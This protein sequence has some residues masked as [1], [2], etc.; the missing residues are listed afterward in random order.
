[1]ATTITSFL[2]IADAQRTTYNSAKPMLLKNALHKNTGHG[3]IA[4]FQGSI[5][6][7]WTALLIALIAANI[8]IGATLYFFRRP[9]R[10]D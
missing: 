7:N 4:S 9:R 8:G 2:T 5:M 1:M 10:K 3:V 6:I